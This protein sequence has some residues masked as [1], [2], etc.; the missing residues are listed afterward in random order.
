ML[1]LSNDYL[2]TNT[3]ELNN[4]N[5]MKVEI[6]TIGDELL[7]GQVIDTNSAWMAGKL[8]EIGLQVVQITS[9]SDQPEAI[10]YSLNLAATRA[11]IIITTGGLGPTKDD[12]TKKTLSEYFNLPLIESV[13]VLKQVTAF[14][15]TRGFKLTD[16]NRMQALIPETCIPLQNSLGTAPGMW[17]EKN[18]VIYISLPGVPYEMMQLME[19]E[20]LPRL[21]SRFP[22]SVVHHQTLLVHGI[23]ESMLA[24]R[25][26][27]WEN[28]LPAGLKL[29]YLPSPGRIRLRL[30]VYNADLQNPES[31]IKQEFL[32]LWQ[33]IPEHIL[34]DQDISLELLLQ[35]LLKEKNLSVAVAESC[36]G[37]TISAM[38]TSEPGASV[39]FKGS[40]IA[41]SNEVKINLLKVSKESLEEQGAVSREVAE[42]M[43]IGVKSQLMSSIGIATTGIAGP[44]GGSEEKP[45]G[46]V[47]IAIAI[48]NQI[49]SKMH[50]FNL[51]RKQN[52]QRA[53]SL[54]LLE[55]IVKINQFVQ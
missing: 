4:K 6:I 21:S 14:I 40:I 32:K 42:Q 24:E 15:H 1:C 22:G 49:F 52:I 51:N 17:I 34:H 23:P 8:N 54:A 20:V 37:G 48:G 39:V 18:D 31:I 36:T 50:R 33:I 35:N 9:I 44:D 3:K 45:V 12:L 43:A 19:L 41:Y 25:I 2:K 27:D 47:W 10:K 30:S 11:N 46:T 16:L 29:A 53:A 7:I 38:I 26:A 5:G 55:A 13:E 28:N